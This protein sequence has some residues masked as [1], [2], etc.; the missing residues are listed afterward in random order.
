MTLGHLD[1]GQVATLIDWYTA[2]VRDGQWG[3]KKGLAD[4]GPAPAAQDTAGDDGW[5]V[6]M[7]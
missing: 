3:G 1:Q 5:Q 2:Q 7:R 4:Y 6:V